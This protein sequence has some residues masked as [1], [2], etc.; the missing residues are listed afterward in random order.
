VRD[1]LANKMSLFYAYPTPMLNAVTTAT[2]NFVSSVSHP[3]FIFFFFSFFFLITPLCILQNQSIPQENVTTC[4]ATMALVCHNAVENPEFASKYTKPETPLFL[5]RVMVGVIILYDHIHPQ[6][7]FV[8]G[9]P[10][11]VSPPAFFF[12]FKFGFFFF[13]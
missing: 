1:E 12:F 8:K 7:A 5:L 9:G 3:C 4:L 2:T 13:F 11:K 6:G 10:I